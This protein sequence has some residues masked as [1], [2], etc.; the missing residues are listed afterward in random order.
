MD[1]ETSP[2]DEDVENL[3]DFFGSPEQIDSFLTRQG[4]HLR[5]QIP[6]VYL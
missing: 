2:D 5:V 1:D 6:L 4:K 3:L